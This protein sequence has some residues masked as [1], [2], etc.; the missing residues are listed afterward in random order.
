MGRH[1]C[2]HAD[3][4]PPEPPR[5]YVYGGKPMSP[6]VIGP[7]RHRAGPAP[8]TASPGCRSESEPLTTRKEDARESATWI[9]TGTRARSRYR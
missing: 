6:P 8:A 4:T 7:R 2:R 1:Q 9:S 3:T 5:R